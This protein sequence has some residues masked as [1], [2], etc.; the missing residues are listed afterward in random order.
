MLLTYPVCL[1]ARQSAAG[2]QPIYAGTYIFE[3]TARY[4]N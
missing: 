3:G 2:C 4:T 1:L